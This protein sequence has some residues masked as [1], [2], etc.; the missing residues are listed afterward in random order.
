MSLYCFVFLCSDPRGGIQAS[1]WEHKCS[2][3]QD[4]LVA[5]QSE[6]ACLRKQAAAAAVAAQSNQKLLEQLQAAEVALADSHSNAQKFQ[7]AHR[8]SQQHLEG[9]ELRG[10]LT[11]TVWALS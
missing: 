8:Q 2:V 1:S 6:A 3:A 10:Q 4:A 11:C 9:N 5:V 7:T